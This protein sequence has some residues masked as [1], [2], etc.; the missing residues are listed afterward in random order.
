MILQ[1][2]KDWYL[3]LACICYRHQACYKMHRDFR[4]MYFVK[5]LSE[6]VILQS[7]CTVCK[8]TAFK[9]LLMFQFHFTSSRS[10]L[11]ELKKI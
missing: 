6:I 9:S 7:F 11:C 3:P 2:E 5:A 4:Y 1:G 10:H 8:M